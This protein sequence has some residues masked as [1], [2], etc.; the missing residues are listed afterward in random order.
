MDGIMYELTNIK[1]DTEKD[2]FRHKIW[3]K[4]LKKT[5]IIDVSKLVLPEDDEQGGFVESLYMVT[6]FILI[7]MVLYVVTLAF[8]VFMGILGYELYACLFLR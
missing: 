5:C 2:Y 1:T 8:C 7:V 3:N 4:E 6:K